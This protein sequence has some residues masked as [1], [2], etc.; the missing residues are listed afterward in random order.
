ME[1]LESVHAIAPWNVNPNDFANTMSV[2]MS[3]NVCPEA[4][5]VAKDYIGAFVGTECRGYIEP[6]YEKGYEK[7]VFYLTVFANSSSETITFKYF[8]GSAAKEYQ[9][10]QNL[11]FANDQITGTVATPFKVDLTSS[12]TCNSLSI[13]DQLN[14]SNVGIYPNPFTNSLK[15]KLTNVDANEVNMSITNGF[16]QTVARPKL[17]NGEWEW[18]WDGTSD[19]G[20]ELSAGVYI[21]S[22]KKADKIA[23][24]KLIKQ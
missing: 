17:T 10:Q 21:L 15:I 3:L 16:G 8:D 18:E 14:V 22:V 23:T 5:D 1:N 4:I 20:N 11:T 7:F 12:V 6:T 9:V 13:S 2:T 24:F 19:S